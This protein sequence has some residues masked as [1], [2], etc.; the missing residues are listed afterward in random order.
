M[1]KIL[2]AKA[3][4]VTLRQQS[5]ADVGALLSTLLRKHEPT[6][7][8]LNGIIKKKV[9]QSQEPPFEEVRLQEFHVPGK[10]R[11]LFTQ[12]EKAL[13]GL[14]ASYRASQEE[15]ARLKQKTLE[16][17][18]ASFHKGFE[19]GLKRGAAEGHA[20]AKKGMDGRLQSLH[21]QVLTALNQVEASRAD[22]FRQAE[23]AIL[24]L[25]NRFA[26]KVVHVESC[27]NP[28][29]LEG[30][31]KNALRF[32]E[33]SQRIVIRVHPD[34]AQK[35]KNELPLWMPVNQALKHISVEED[36]RI[37][38]GGCLVDTETGQIDARLET[39]MDELEAA[40]LRTWEDRA[41]QAQPPAP[42]Q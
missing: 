12:E 18:K 11:N 15:I 37:Q 20:Q 5:G 36:A 9:D 7:A 29:V 41:S 30:V 4:K 27:I 16:I 1:G 8:H 33:E 40:I 31:A 32:V 23:R 10:S 28:A 13:I 22:L 26:R 39:M 24:E 6:W 19:E 34:Q 35:V 25:V 42:A 14:E 17:Q 2:H 38:P 3:P 21:K